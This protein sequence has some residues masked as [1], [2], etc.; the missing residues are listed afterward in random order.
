MWYIHP[1]W[2][3]SISNTQIK[4]SWDVLFLTAAPLYGQFSFNVEMTNPFLT[5]SKFLNS[6]TGVSIHQL[7]LSILPPSSIL[8]QYSFCSCFSF[9]LQATVTTAEPKCE[10]QRHNCSQCCQQ[11]IGIWNGNN[12][13]HNSIHCLLIFNTFN[14]LMINSHCFSLVP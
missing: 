9:I 13:T 10:H 2:L 6:N 5:I 1:P 3:F 11:D 14:C 7:T 12:D 4:F 8:L